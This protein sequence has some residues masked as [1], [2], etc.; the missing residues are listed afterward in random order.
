MTAKSEETFSVSDAYLDEFGMFRYEMNSIFK[1]HQYEDEPP[2]EMFM[3]RYP[4]S[5]T[6]SGVQIKNE[7]ESKKCNY[8][9]VFR[10]PGLVEI[11]G[12]VLE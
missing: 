6:E 5:R 7:E 3:G 4:L 2:S 11:R 12:R 9:D 10:P 8:A 1:R